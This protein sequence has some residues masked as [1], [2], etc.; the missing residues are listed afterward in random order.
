MSPRTRNIVI[1]VVV[2]VL[3]VTVVAPFVYLNFIKDDPAPE[4]TLDDVSTTTT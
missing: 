4:L 1:G 3:L 2:A